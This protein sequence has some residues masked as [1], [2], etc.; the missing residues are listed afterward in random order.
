MAG[1]VSPFVFISKLCLT[2]TL[3]AWTLLRD[4]GILEEGLEDLNAGQSHRA[5]LLSQSLPIY[6][7][8]PPNRSPQFN[9]LDEARRFALEVRGK[10]HAR[11]SGRGGRGGGIVGS[12][13]RRYAQ[14]RSVSHHI[15]MSTI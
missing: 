12:Q 4:D 5:R 9:A 3:A 11:G 10:S 8:L 14:R 1:I 7:P 2:H 15:C 6:V 13:L